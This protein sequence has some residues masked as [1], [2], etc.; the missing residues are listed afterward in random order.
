[1]R[2]NEPWYTR[3]CGYG[4]GVDMELWNCRFGVSMLFWQMSCIYF[5]INFHNSYCNIGMTQ[6]WYEAEDLCFEVPYVKT[7]KLIQVNNSTSAQSE[8]LKNNA[9][10]ALRCIPRLSVWRLYE[11]LCPAVGRWGGDEWDRT[12]EVLK[13]LMWCCEHYGKSL[14]L[15]TFGLFINLIWLSLLTRISSPP[16]LGFV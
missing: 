2:L 15:Q 5:C 8:F 13:V 14:D 10:W 11:L 7:T 9:R 3:S 4:T 12:C 16:P 1:M 6:L